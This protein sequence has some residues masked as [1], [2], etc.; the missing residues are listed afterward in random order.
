MTKPSDA[1]SERARVRRLHERGHYD[2]ATIDAILDAMPLCHVGIV[3]GGAPVVTPTL[4]WREGDHVY[5]HG[6]AA[7]RMLRA[8]EGCEVCL[9]VSILDGLVLARSAFHHSVNFRSVMLF[10]RAQKVADPADKAMRLRAFVEGLYPGR[11][12]TL[13]AM[14]EQELKA[15]T[16]L[17]MPIVEAS[18]KVRTGPPK[19]D[20]EDYALPIWAGVVPVQL[21]LLAPE[22]DPRNLPGIEAPEP[23]S[24]LTL[25]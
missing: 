11:W 17:T 5:W 12:E 23:L 14:T 7:S 13:R 20:E 21:A 1:P 10:G 8:A 15:T 18:A 22:P 19:D 6:S 2:R 16:V 9:T 24:A 4:Q 3:A 25:R